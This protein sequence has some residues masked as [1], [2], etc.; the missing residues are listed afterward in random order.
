MSNK[1]ILQG[2]NKALESLTAIAG[3][4]IKIKER[5]TPET[6]GFTKMAVDEFTFT[7]DTQVRNATLTHSLGEPPK[8]IIILTDIST[9]LPSSA[10]KEVFAITLTGSWT[11]K[12]TGLYKESTYY[13]PISSPGQVTATSTNI[14]LD[15]FNNFGGGVKYTLITMA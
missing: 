4:Q 8:Q 7:S 6:F 15:L 3:I 14:S 11:D 1:K 5:I 9:D 10:I 13:S 12:A 2:H